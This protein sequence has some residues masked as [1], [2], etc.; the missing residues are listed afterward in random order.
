[1]CRPVR[2][3]RKPGGQT[4]DIHHLA[5]P[6]DGATAQMQQRASHAPEGYAAPRGR[7]P[8]SALSH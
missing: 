7:Y 2:A 8:R 6:Q 4:R 1:M 3:A 5:M